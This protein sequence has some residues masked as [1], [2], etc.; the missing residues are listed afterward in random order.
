MS[1]LFS[2]HTSIPVSIAFTICLMK[3]SW[4]GYV[5][6]GTWGLSS[7]G[8]YVHKN[9]L[10]KKIGSSLHFLIIVTQPSALVYLSISNLFS[11]LFCCTCAIY[12]CLSLTLLLTFSLHFNNFCS[13]LSQSKFVSASSSLFS[14]ISMIC[15]SVNALV[16]V[17]MS[18][19]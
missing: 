15:L 5:M 2:I 13:K 4:Y 11:L 9:I 19:V 18:V 14:S 12:S 6:N 16:V 7:L 3:S 8:L 17:S 10:K 1:L